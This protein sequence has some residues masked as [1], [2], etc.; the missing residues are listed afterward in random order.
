MKMHKEGDR[1]PEPAPGSIA[2]VASLPAP[3]QRRF[4]KQCMMSPRI[5]S[6]LRSVFGGVGDLLREGLRQAEQEADG[7]E[8]LVKA[9]VESE[10][11]PEK[12]GLGPGNTAVS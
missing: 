5:G 7:V 2:S 8:A 3:D 11:K 1:C 4:M 9:D 6:L 12:Q 10:D